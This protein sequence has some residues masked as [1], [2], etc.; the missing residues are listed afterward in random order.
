MDS[1]QFQIGDTVRYTPA[2][3]IATVVGYTR[4]GSASDPTAVILYSLDSGVI[5]FARWL[6][7]VAKE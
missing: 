3:V 1:E 5:A 4:L 7:R 2:N 6:E